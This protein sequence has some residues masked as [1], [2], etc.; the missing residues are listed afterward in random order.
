MQEEDQFFVSSG[1]SISEVQKE[2]YLKKKKEI[3]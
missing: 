2:I 1:E 3:Y